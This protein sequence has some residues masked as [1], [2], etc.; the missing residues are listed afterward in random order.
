MAS[1]NSFTQGASRISYDSDM[2]VDGFKDHLKEAFDYKTEYDY[3]FGNLM[4][5]Y[6][7]EIEAEIL[8]Y[9][10]MKVLKTFDRRKDAESIGAVVMS[11]RN[12]TRSWFKSGSEDDDV[13]AKASA[14]IANKGEFLLLYFV[15]KDQDGFLSK[16]AIRGCYDGSLLE[17]LANMHKEAEGKLVAGSSSPP[18]AISGATT[19]DDPMATMVLS[20]SL[21]HS[22]PLPISTSLSPNSPITARPAISFTGSSAATSATAALSSLS[23]NSSSSSPYESHAA[24]SS[25]FLS[26]QQLPSSSSLPLPTAAIA[27]V[28]LPAHLTA[29]TSLAH[30]LSTTPSFSALNF[31]AAAALHAFS[32]QTPSSSSSQPP[33][34]PPLPLLS[35]AGGPNPAIPISSTS[36]VEIPSAPSLSVAAENHPHFAGAVSPAVAWPPAGFFFL[37]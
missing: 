13:Y 20:S 34:F 30:I 15:A 3:K 19:S 1:F 8:S 12:E 29:D 21:P 2:E 35:S 7:L 25:V 32:G 9:G 16:E 33:L 10:I 14:W 26:Q 17:Y 37:P 23:L 31:S 11:L 22:S 6:G 36:A 27:G 24:A 4:D 18:P 5:Y 28:P